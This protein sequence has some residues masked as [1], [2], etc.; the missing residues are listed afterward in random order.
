MKDGRKEAS[1][2]SNL[3]QRC[4]RRVRGKK[5]NV[6]GGDAAKQVRHS[7]ERLG[8]G[9][10]GC[11]GGGLGGIEEMMMEGVRGGVVG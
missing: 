10:G 2:L 6:V 11:G 3:F 5:R 1:C 7:S 9:G 8:E 4:C